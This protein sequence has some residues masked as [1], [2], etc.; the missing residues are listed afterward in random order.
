MKTAIEVITPSVAET[1]LGQNHSNRKIRPAHVLFLRDEILEGRWQSNG[2]TIVFGEEGRLLDGQHRLLAVKAA[3]KPI[4]TL[5]VHGVPNAFFSTIDMG[6]PRKPADTL[7]IMGES[8]TGLLAST[9][10][11]ILR[12]KKGEAGSFTRTKTSATIVEKFLESNSKVRRSVEM[13]VR[14]KIMSSPVAAACHYLFAQKDHDLADKFLRGV[15]E[16]AEIDRDDPIFLFRER[17]IENLA[18]KAKLH[19]QY[20]MA[21]M[22]KAWNSLRKKERGVEL[23][24]KFSESFPQI[25]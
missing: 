19:A 23:S 5:V 13:C 17:M 11:W 7:K 8:D 6:A 4:R 2:A 14:M 1:Y 12:Y 22:I 25:V 21:L 16:G 10:M 15:R 24:F 3:N 18:S 20:Q 9:I